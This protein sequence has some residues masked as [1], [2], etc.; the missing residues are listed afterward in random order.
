MDSCVIFLK[1]EYGAD[2]MATVISTFFCTS[3]PIGRM[4]RTFC[5]EAFGNQM[6]SQKLSSYSE[7]HQSY[8]TGVGECLVKESRVRLLYSVLKK[9]SECD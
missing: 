1:L 9:G 4:H 3:G 6:K 2:I 8:P 7:N 5:V